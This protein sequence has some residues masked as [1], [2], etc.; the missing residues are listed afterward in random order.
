MTIYRWILLSW[1]MFYIKALEKIKTHI[2]CSVTFYRNSCRLWDNVEKCGG[3][4]EATDDNTMTHACCMLDKQGYKR[5]RTCTCPRARAS[6]HPATHRHIHARAR[7]HAHTQICK[8]YCFS[9]AA[10]VSRTRRVLRA[11][12]SLLLFIFTIIFYILLIMPGW[13]TSTHTLR[14]N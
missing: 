9:T 8:T 12:P 2:L 11:L 5:S 7:T 1:E 13:W 3:T 10:V 4:R 14:H 6:T